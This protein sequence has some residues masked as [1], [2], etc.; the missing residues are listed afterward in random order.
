MT[1]SLIG[2]HISPN[3]QGMTEDKVNLLKRR[4]DWRFLLP[5][6]NPGKSI[7]FSDGLIAEAMKL[8]LKAVIN[9]G[10]EYES[11]SYDLAVAVNPDINI[12]NAVNSALRPGGICYLEWDANIF[13]KKSATRKLLN[14][15]GFD[16]TYFYMPKPEPEKPKTNIWIPLESVGA[17]YYLIK[18]SE[19]LIN[20]HII[21]QTAKFI[22]NQMSFIIPD[23]VLSNPFLLS[24]TPN[25]FTISTISHKRVLENNAEADKQNNYGLV[26]QFI[27]DKVISDKPGSRISLLMITKGRA[28]HNKIALIVFQER[29]LNPLTVVKIARSD[30]SVEPLLNETYILKSLEEKFGEITGVPKI[31][32]SKN[33]ADLFLTGQTFLSGVPLSGRLKRENFRDLAYKVTSWLIE[34]AERTKTGLTQD[35][36]NIQTD[37]VV[38]SFSINYSPV[39]NAEQITATREIMKDL[40]IPFLVCEHRDVGPWNIM[41]NDDS[42]LGL[43]D[44]ESSDLY[45]LPGRDLIYFLLYIGLYTHGNWK[46]EDVYKCYR[47]M[48][49]PATF[50]GSIFHESKTRYFSELGLPESTLKSVRVL[51][52]LKHSLERFDRWYGDSRKKLVPDNLRKNIYFI[53]WE[54]E[55]SDYMNRQS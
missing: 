3:L 11:N 43:A 8:K 21:R 4:I 55:V 37:S 40:S 14:S 47:E 42:K 29:D 25:K 2:N 17:L 9:S 16:E 49:D 28:V 33:D 52:W 41:I 22:R 50:F 24:S 48:L 1:K 19:N 18:H 44:W 27:L 6:P 34:F 36:R 45:G 54:L 35:W 26:P 15:L 30:I 39:V 32:F 20:E 38:T 31:I 23:F 13:F 10:D 46:T 5:D 51:T 12:L 7:C 53:C